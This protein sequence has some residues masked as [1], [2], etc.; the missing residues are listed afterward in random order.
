MKKTCSNEISD[1]LKCDE[2]WLDPILKTAKIDFSQIIF[3][4]F[5]KEDVVQYFLET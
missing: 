4:Y 2:A 3:L 5:L 1:I